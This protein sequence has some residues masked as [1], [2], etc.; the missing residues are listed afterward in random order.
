M[1]VDFAIVIT[2]SNEMVVIWC[3]CAHRK[4][5]TVNCIDICAVIALAEDALN[6][7]ANGSCPGV[8]ALI[9][10]Y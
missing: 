7:P 9:K 5:R 1:N 3:T 2:G 4:M 8:P 6:W 10:K